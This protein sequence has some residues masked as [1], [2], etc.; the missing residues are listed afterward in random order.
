MQVWQEAQKKTMS[1]FDSNLEIKRNSQVGLAEKNP[2]PV[3]DWE[4][5]IAAHL[6]WLDKMDKVLQ[7]RLTMSIGEAVDHTQFKLGRLLYERGL[8]DYAYLS[9]ID[10]IEQKHVELHATVREIIEAYTT[11]RFSEARKQ[12]ERLLDISRELV[13]LLQF[14]QMEERLYDLDEALAVGAQI[15]KFLGR[16]SDL[17]RNYFADIVLWSKPRDGVSG[18]FFH[19]TAD[20]EH[21]TLFLADCTGHGVAAAM[22]GIYVQTIVKG[23]QATFKTNSLS[24]LVRYIVEYFH[25]LKSEESDN[26]ATLQIGFEFA[27]VRYYP[28]IRKLE[29]C[30]DGID[31]WLERGGEIVQISAE[32]KNMKCAE[33]IAEPA[34][35][36]FMYTDGLTDQFGGPDNRKLGRKRVHAAIAENA[37]LT[38]G[39]QV[40]ALKDLL[41]NWQL[42]ARQTDDVTVVAFEI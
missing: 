10:E 14:A 42:G 40:Q 6:E 23:V 34:D 39:E 12:Y 24:E 20:D 29:F 25:N 38:L 28:K 8:K 1:R 7:G 18:D 17:P 31:L 27:A 13:R 32:D 2:R 21:C 37:Q 33:I 19:C 11:N 3:A 4:G 16:H 26:P 9:C 22:V 35:R 5:A 30:G 41:W 36:F 15:Q